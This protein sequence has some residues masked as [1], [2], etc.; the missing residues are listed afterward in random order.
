MMKDKNFQAFLIG[1]LATIAGWA[2]TKLLDD[3]LSK[4]SAT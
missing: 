3:Y 4:K 1:V 2:A